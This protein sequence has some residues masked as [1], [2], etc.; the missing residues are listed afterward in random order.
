MFIVIHKALYTCAAAHRIAGLDR[1]HS[2][3]ESGSDNVLAFI[4]KGYTKAQEIEAGRKVKDSGIELSI[5]Y[6]PGAGGRALSDENAFETADVVNQINPDFVRIRTFVAQ[7]G[8]EL[9][10]DFVAGRLVECTDKEKL[11]ELKRMLEHI[12]GVDGYL[13]S[14]HIINMLE[15]IY[16]NMGTEKAR[17]LSVI[18]EFEGLEL[19]DQREYQIARRMGMVRSLNQ[20]FHLNAE[21]REIVSLQLAQHKTDE[22]FEAFLSMLLRR[23]I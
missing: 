9:H 10:D 20:F 14:D 15:E 6:M 16:G 12:D 8:T 5:Y 18:A 13:Y 1:I 4:N 23:Y 7:K 11:L 19:Q 22:S 21:A 3:F 17:M 2:G